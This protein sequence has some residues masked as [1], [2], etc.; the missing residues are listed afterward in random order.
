MKRCDWCLGLT[1]LAL[2]AFFAAPSADGALIINEVHFDPA[3]HVD[4]RGDANNDGTAHYKEDEFVEILNTGPAT[5][6][7]S[8]YRLGDNDVAF[9][10]MFAFPGGTTMHV[11]EMI[12]VFGGGTPDGFTNQ[13]FTDDGSIGSG[14]GN[15]N[16]NVWLISDDQADTVEVYWGSA[17]PLSSGAVQITS[18]S[19]NPDASYTR[20]PDGGGSWED[21]S[22]ADTDDNSLYSPG[23]RIT[24]EANLPVRLAYFRGLPAS[25]GVHIEWRTVSEDGA[26]HFEV[27]RADNPAMEGKEL[28]HVVPAAPGGYSARPIDYS[29]VDNG[30]EEGVRYWYAL[31]EIDLDSS[32]HH[33]GQFE[34]VTLRSNA[35]LPA[36]R[37][38]ELAQNAPNPFNPRT[39][40]AFTVAEATPVRLGIYDLAGNMIRRLVDAERGA[41]THRVVWDGRDDRGADVSSGVYLYRIETD[42]G[43]E[44]RQMVLVK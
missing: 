19:S 31:D 37:H 14:L 34:I 28:T 15:D 36:G 20:D 40:I 38:L 29:V 23:A 12:T 8:N 39:T 1:A 7:I 9:G 26:S 44:A 3:S 42:R 17:V 32:L 11:N 30:L 27:Y 2:A 43:A 24:G 5:V 10:S 16:E 41:G 13:V 33:Y 6:N 4:Q 22:V 21:H 35:G 25:D 18:A